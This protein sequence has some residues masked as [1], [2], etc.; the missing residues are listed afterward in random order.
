M[1]KK[2]NYQDF[3]NGLDGFYTQAKDKHSVYL[4]FKRCNSYDLTY[5]I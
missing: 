1:V 2:L 5:S 4:T 3:V